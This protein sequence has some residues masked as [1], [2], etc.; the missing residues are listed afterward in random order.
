[1]LTPN[2]YRHH[3]HTAEFGT[4]T[5]MK[6]GDDV[7][8]DRDGVYRLLICMLFPLTKKQ[9]FLFLFLFKNFLFPKLPSL[10]TIIITHFLI[11]SFLYFFSRVSLSVCLMHELNL[12][13]N[14]LQ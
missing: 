4:Q 7:D 14:L 11:F 13:V 6:V 9:A 2:K 8:T 10:F 3:G 1:M 12:T 5:G